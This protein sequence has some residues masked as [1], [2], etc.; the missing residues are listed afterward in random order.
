MVGHMHEDIDQMFSCVSRRLSKNNARTLLE[1][2]REIAMSYS[3]AIK[4]TLLTFMYDVKQWLDECAVPNLSGHIYDHQFK[5]VRGPG[6]KARFYYK[7]WSTSGT[8]YP[9][10]GIKLIQRKPKECQNLLSPRSPN[11][12]WRNYGK[13]FQSTTS[14]LTPKPSSGG[15]SFLTVRALFPARDQS[16]CFRS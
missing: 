7:K 13:T 2:I 14:T 15:K 10:E 6:G 11:S 9:E 5:I 8:W 12:T 3:R 16:G 1:L 4:S